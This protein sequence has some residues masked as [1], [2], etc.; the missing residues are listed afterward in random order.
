MHSLGLTEAAVHCGGPTI[1]VGFSAQM[2]WLVFL[3]LGG[4]GFLDD[5]SAHVAVCRHGARG[6][7][8]L[9]A[10]EMAAA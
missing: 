2:S 8:A 1:C 7:G 4:S 6:P 10:V 5:R 3:F 9:R